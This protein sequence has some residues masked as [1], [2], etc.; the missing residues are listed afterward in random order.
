MAQAKKKEKTNVFKQSK[1]LICLQKCFLAEN[2]YVNAII[3]RAI[4]I[5]T[6]LN[7]NVFFFFEFLYA[8]NSNVMSVFENSKDLLG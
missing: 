5:R 3:F 8:A 7:Y 1:T 4:G 2:N 6:Q